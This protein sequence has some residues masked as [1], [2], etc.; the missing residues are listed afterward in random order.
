VGYIEKPGATWIFAMNIDM[1]GKTGLPLRQALTQASQKA[2]GIIEQ[3][4]GTGAAFRG[5]TGTL[6][7]PA[8]G[9]TRIFWSAVIGSLRGYNW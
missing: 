8:S 6:Q 4:G 9:V 3:S 2:K 5:G 1:R 7:W